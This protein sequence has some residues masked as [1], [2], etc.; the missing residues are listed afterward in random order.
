MERQMEH[1]AQEMAQRI[2]EIREKMALAAQKAGRC[3][4]EVLL[5]AASKMQEAETVRTA[6]AL[7]I[8][9]FGE[10]R[11][12]ELVEKLQH[13]AYGEKPVH[14]IGHLQTNKVKQ[15]VGNVALIQSIGSLHLMEAVEK[16]AALKEICQ[17]ILLQVNIGG[18]ESKSGFAQEDLSEA[19]ETAQRFSHLHVEGLMAIP[20]IRQ[21]DEENRRD[22]ANVRRCFERLAS[23]CGQGAEMRW[24][25]MGMS[26]DFEN[27][28]LEG[29]NLVRVG[30]SIFGARNYP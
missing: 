9:L 1:S 12:Q 25:S 2:Q 28:I 3:A 13:S 10:N 6:S 7:N 14:F 22:L 18:E 29:A 27:A 8:D 17:P 26:G 16:Q 23:Q 19:L 11:V 4:Q 5:C 21:T 20:P 30:T 15:V 24:L